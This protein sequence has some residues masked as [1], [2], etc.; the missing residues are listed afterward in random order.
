D[1]TGGNGPY[2]L[3]FL[4]AVDRQHPLLAVLVT[5]Q[6]DK[7]AGH[8]GGR[9]ALAQP[10]GLPKQFWPSF[11]PGAQEALLVAAGVAP[12]PAPGRP[13]ARTFGRQ[14][15]PRAEDNDRTND[16]GQTQ[17]GRALSIRAGLSGVSMHE[18]TE[19]IL[20]HVAPFKPQ[21]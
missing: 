4:R 15:A 9:V 14:P 20:N 2:A 5:H 19:T 17:H 7:V 13:I 10:L 16:G 8:A 3:A 12:R 1:R 11:G 18:A 21:K 6:V